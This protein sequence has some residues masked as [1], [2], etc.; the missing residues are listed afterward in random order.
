[1]K[2]LPAVAELLHADGQAEKHVTK[3]IVT[4]SNFVNAPKRRQFSLFP[5]PGL[6]GRIVQSV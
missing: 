6:G 2:I 5:Q 1:M 4:F 3:L